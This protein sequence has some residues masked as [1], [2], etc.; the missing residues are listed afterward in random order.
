M[1]FRKNNLGAYVNFLKTKLARMAGSA[2]VDATPYYLL[3]DPSS[4][5]PL[6]CSMCVDPKDPARRVRPSRLMTPELFENLMGELGENLFMLSLYNWGEP[7]LNPDLN[8]FIR[9]AKEKDIFVDINTN[10]SLE[11]TDED[12]EAFLDTGIDNIVVSIDGF[13]Q[14]TY[15]T[16]RIGGSFE[17]ARDNITRL[18]S[19]RDRICPATAITWK[20]LV[21]SFNE[22]EISLAERYCR[23]SGI[24]FARKEA[25]VDLD[26]HPEWLPS[27]RRADL[28]RPHGGWPFRR[29]VPPVLK[30]IGR[31]ATCAWHYCYS[32]INADGSVS[33]CCA[34]PD[35]KDDFGTVVPGKMRFTDV[36]NGESYRR[37]RA[38]LAGEE[39]GERTGRD[40]V[41]ARCPYPFL[42]DL[43]T[44]MD[45]FIISRF[46][47]IHAAGEPDLAGAF[48]GLTGRKNAPAPPR[49]PRVPSAP[50]GNAAAPE[51]RL[52][53][54]RG[55]CTVCGAETE[56]TLKKAGFSLRETA[57]GACGA[58]RRNRDLAAGILKTHG[59]DPCGSLAG[60]LSGL[61][62]L[63]IF[64]AQADGPVHRVLKRLPGY[65]AAEFLDGVPLGSNHASGVRCEDLERLTF[66]DGS[67]DLVITQ[68]VFEHVVR[69]AEAFR[70]IARILKPGGC[71]IFTVPLHD[72]RKTVSRVRMDG[73]R[74]EHVLPPVYHGDPLRS[75]GSLV[76]TDFGDD[77]PA[78]LAPLG[79]DTD[80]VCRET[81][82]PPDELPWIDDPRSHERYLEYRRRGEL[83]ACLRY[84]SVVFRSRR[85]N[86]VDEGVSVLFREVMEMLV[87]ERVRAEI[88]ISAGEACIAAGEFALAERLFSKALEGAKRPSAGSPEYSKI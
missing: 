16:Y 86:P 13:S 5:C 85:R 49:N 58:T 57:C 48:A 55:V 78:L 64:E 40:P 74:K 69:P 71:H 68:D 12:L 23:K 3:V 28:S 42:K 29:T 53:H 8:R 65:L 82:Y 88:T 36:W 44:G 47:K 15:G 41:C 80:V 38:L 26:V 62:R 19:L 24:T 4:C 87:D 17:L 39:E 2:V 61:S 32:S 43:S 7:L 21:F 46:Q 76:V 77:L 37:S 25:T 60:Q 35:A 10:L 73:D 54:G 33:P 84:N 56:F 30:E 79:F 31:E 20:Y 27:Y 6:R 1:Q 70:E 72:G 66:A 67:F 22:H 34:V 52:V 45:Q 63:A 50:P 14:E 9:R 81:F 11:L 51:T 83:L 59:L 75:S 18:A